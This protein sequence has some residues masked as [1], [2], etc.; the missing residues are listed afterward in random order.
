MYTINI[1]SSKDFD[2][3][4]VNA[5]KGS[6]VSM[7]LGFANRDT[8]QAYVRYTELGELNSYLV[9]HEFEELVQDESTHEDTNGIRHKDLKQTFGKLLPIIGGVGGGLVG[10]PVGA[11]IGGALGGAGGRLLSG[12]GRNFRSV[13]GSALKSGALA[14]GTSALTGNFGIPGSNVGKGIATSAGTGVRTSGAGLLNRLGQG[15]ASGFGVPATLKKA[16][17]ALS[18][19]LGGSPAQA[20]QAGGGAGGPGGG[21]G[22]SQALQSTLQRLTPP[23]FTQAGSVNQTNEPQ[24]ILNKF[25]GL[26]GKNPRLAAGALTAG[27]SQLFK[28]PQVPEL[29]QSIRDF[30]SQ[31]QSGTQLGQAGQDKLQGLLGQDFNPLTEPELQAGRREI[32]RSFTDREDQIRDLFRNIRP[33]TDESTDSAL[34]KELEDNARLRSNALADFAANRTR[35]IK[36]DFDQQR[37][38]QILA[39]QGS[40]AQDLAQQLQAANFDVEQVIGQFNVDD[41]DQ[42]V[43]RNFLLQFGGDLAAS[44][45]GSQQQNPLQ[46]LLSAFGGGQ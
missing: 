44:S 24:G 32:E 43:L 27:A 15:V 33:G 31:A 20:A 26:L 40:S 42:E 29:P 1:L 13:G 23:G 18:G 11:G 36:S 30:Q 5:T 37:L 25:G 28:S 19:F 7:S 22:P 45:L 16:G 14:A 17:G 21:G 12:G 6:D 9:D 34:N 8:G 10:G 35:E 39:S 3:L 46:G 38:N 41:R 2:K 4:G